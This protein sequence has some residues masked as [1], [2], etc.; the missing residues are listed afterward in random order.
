M[1]SGVRVQP[2][3]R[4]RRDHRHRGEHAERDHAGSSRTWQQSPQRLADP[5]Q[6][7]DQVTGETPG[8]IL[9]GPGTG[10]RV[11]A[12]PECVARGAVWQAVRAL[13]GGGRPQWEL[14]I[15]HTVPPAPAP[16]VRENYAAAR[17]NVRRGSY[18]SRTSCTS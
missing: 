9:L 2:G 11:P 13:A 8:G 18:D 14:S 12:P 5:Q 6:D 3:G 7:S 1:G 4:D 10:D 15:A 16:R 17:A